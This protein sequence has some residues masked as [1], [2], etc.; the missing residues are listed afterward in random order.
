MAESQINELEKF[1]TRNLMDCA[2]W[3]RSPSWPCCDLSK[4]CRGQ[5]VGSPVSSL[6]IAALFSEHHRHDSS[7]L[8]QNGRLILRLLLTGNE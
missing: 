2:S 8:S 4:S 7:R 5:T 1:Q 3:G 6:S